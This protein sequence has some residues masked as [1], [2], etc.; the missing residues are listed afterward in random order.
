ML[1][2]LMNV[3]THLWHTIYQ[4]KR[5]FRIRLSVHNNNELIL[6]L[7]KHPYQHL[8]TNKKRVLS[9]RENKLR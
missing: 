7:D 4:H 1:E 2:V 6:L 9:T 5:Y 8:S 3:S